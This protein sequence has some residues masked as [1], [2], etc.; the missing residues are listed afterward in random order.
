MLPNFSLADDNSAFN[1]ASLSDMSS[2]DCRNF[3]LDSVSPSALANSVARTLTWCSSSF[4]RLTN[5]SALVSASSVRF[6]ASAN[7]TCIELISKLTFSTLSTCIFLV[8][9]ASLVLI[10]AAFLD[11]SAED[12]F[13]F[14]K[15]FSFSNSSIFSSADS[16]LRRKPASIPGA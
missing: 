1:P 4:T 10:S 2:I 9:T 3:S 6:L 12:N 16:N 8:S 5:L 14:S 7:S 15:D 13:E 11:A